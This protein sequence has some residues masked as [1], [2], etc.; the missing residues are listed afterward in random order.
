[1]P[2]HPLSPT[3][4]LLAALALSL[5]VLVTGHGPAMAASQP[6]VEIYVTSWCPYC[7]K[8]IAY[9][10]AK[11]VPYTTYDIEKDSAAAA[12]FRQYGKQGVPLTVINGVVISGYAVSEFEKALGADKPAPAA[13][14]KIVTSP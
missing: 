10:Q 7:K 8:T 11:G 2:R 6:S 5:T 3:R 4:S 9:F 14:P 13:P 12:R 1:M